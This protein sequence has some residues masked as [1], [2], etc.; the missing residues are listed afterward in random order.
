MSAANVL[1]PSSIA[2]LIL[3]AEKM[4]PADA[5]HGS[6]RRTPKQNKPPVSRK[7]LVHCLGGI[8]DTV[9]AFAA[10]R[11]LRQACPDDYI[12]VL[13]MW[14]QAADLLGDIGIFDEV[15]QHHFQ[16]DRYWRSLLVTLALRMRGFD[17]S[18]LGFP[19]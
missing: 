10:L 15:I 18:I 11:D 1:R 4:R 17:V 19:T 13:T 12:V 3:D 7:I 5:A 6:T 2:R 14:P 16:K 9:L 8:G